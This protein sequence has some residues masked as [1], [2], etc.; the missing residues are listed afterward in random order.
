M[1]A[2]TVLSMVHSTSDQGTQDTEL[3]CELLHLVF[4]LVL[5]VP[6]LAFTTFCQCLIRS[7]KRHG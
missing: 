5:L 4:A 3:F 6:S 7:A 1:D 2:G